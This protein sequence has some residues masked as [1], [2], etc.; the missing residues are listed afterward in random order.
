MA[1]P[2]GLLLTSN[3]LFLVALSFISFTPTCLYFLVPTFFFFHS[4]CLPIS[5]LLL[6]LLPPPS[7]LLFSFCP[8]YSFPFHPLSTPTTSTL[9]RRFS[10]P[11]LERFFNCFGFKSQL[12][13]SLPPFSLCIPLYPIRIS[14]FLFFIS[15][16]VLYGNLSLASNSNFSR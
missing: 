16:S 9:V 15:L 2:H 10:I 1:R 4:F 7:S 5:N 12:P 13:A 6:H 8:F 11:C 3:H 14:F